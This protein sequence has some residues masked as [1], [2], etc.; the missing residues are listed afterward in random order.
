M[1]TGVFLAG[2][3]PLREKQKGEQIPPSEVPDGTPHLQ[4]FQSHIHPDDRQ[5]WERRFWACLRGAPHSAVVAF[6]TLWLVKGSDMQKTIKSVS[7][8]K[9][10]MYQPVHQAVRPTTGSR[11]HR[12]F[13]ETEIFLGFGQLLLKEKG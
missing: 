4:N 7:S 1:H 2:W 13:L 9:R 11:T 10:R 12:P 8:R 3:V 6:S 5:M